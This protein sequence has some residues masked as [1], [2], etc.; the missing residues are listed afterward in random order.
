M[1]V[2]FLRPNGQSRIV[3]EDSD[4]AILIEAGYHRI[5]VS[6]QEA[7]QTLASLGLADAEAPKVEAPKV[8][9]KKPAPKKRGSKIVSRAE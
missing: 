9:K 2:E 5:D 1:A 3:V 4:E 7:N 6:D 8:E